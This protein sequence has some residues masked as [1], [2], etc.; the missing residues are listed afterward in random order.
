M[1]RLQIALGTAV[2]FAL[3]TMAAEPAKAA[4]PVKVIELKDLKVGLAEGGDVA[5]PI[6]ITSEDELAKS[7]S[8]KDAQG[9]IRKQVDFKAQK[10]LFFSWAGSGQDKLTY[11]VEGD[12]KI[13]VTF[14]YQ[15]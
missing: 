1:H 9:V 13:E 11:Q 2:L 14:N 7:V 15:A 5:K 8:D 10:I 4:D 3:A 6:A 12:K